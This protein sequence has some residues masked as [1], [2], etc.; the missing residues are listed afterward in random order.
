MLGTVS[1]NERFHETPI[2]ILQG[3]TRCLAQAAGASSQPRPD[4]DKP[5]AANHSKFGTQLCGRTPGMHYQ[6]ILHVLSDDGWEF[7]D[8]EGDHIEKTHARR[9]LDFKSLRSRSGQ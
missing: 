1:R 9:I 4:I 2:K 6:E 7:F 3:I 8:L 5:N